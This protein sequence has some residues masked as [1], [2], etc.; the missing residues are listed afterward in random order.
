MSKHY[1]LIEGR[2]IRGT[3]TL[4]DDA[5]LSEVR[6]L[7]ND[8]HLNIVPMEK[9]VYEHLH[10]ERAFSALSVQLQRG[11]ADAFQDKLEKSILSGK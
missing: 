2:T 5:A 11:A 4:F 9:G 3:I 1:A 8:S 6:P 10:D 7:F